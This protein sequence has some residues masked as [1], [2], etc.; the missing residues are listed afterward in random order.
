MVQAQAAK[1]LMNRRRLPIH[2]VDDEE[3]GD[4]EDTDLNTV[5]GVLAAVQRM[6]RR[7]GGGRFAPRVNQRPDRSGDAPRPG[8]KCPNCGEEHSLSQC[9]KP[10]VPSNERKCWTCNGKGHISSKCP[11]KTQRKP[12]A[13]KNV[14]EEGE[15]PIFGLSPQD[16]RS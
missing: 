13:L 5:E 3:D 6:M 15:I 14:S 8:R 9:K 11:H 4:L 1:V 12:G 2:H 10:I 16:G 7:N